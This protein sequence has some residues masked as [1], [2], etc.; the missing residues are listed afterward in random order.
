MSQHPE[1]GR[2]VALA[3]D[4][5]AGFTRSYADRGVRV[6]RVQ[7][8][9]DSETGFPAILV[10]LTDPRVEGERCFDY[11]LMDSDGEPEGPADAA[12]SLAIAMME[13]LDQKRDPL[14][15]LPLAPWAT[16]DPD[17]SLPPG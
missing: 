2:A 17:T 3:K 4:A 9:E 12:Q 1:H 15:Q 11:P 10:G 5:V 13:F 16:S 7:L 8:G 6:T 14:E